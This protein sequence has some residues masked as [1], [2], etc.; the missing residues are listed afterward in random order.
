[1]AD[2]A[3]PRLLTWAPLVTASFIPYIL[4]CAYLWRKNRSFHLYGTSGTWKYFLFGAVMGVL[5]MGST[6]IYGAASDQLETMGPILGWPLFMASIIL[7]S[8]AWGFATGEWK[9]A[10]RKPRAY[11]F[12][13]IGLLILG[14]V[15]LAYASNLA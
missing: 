4:Y 3:I 7:T 11:I 9:G 15:V 6:A 12:S 1:M 8:N 5:W 2:P 13:G 10:G 14:F